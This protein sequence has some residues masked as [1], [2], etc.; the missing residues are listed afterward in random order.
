MSLA[1]NV[2]TVGSATLFSRV[3]GFA[4]DMGIAAVFG[5][6]I[7]ADAFFVAF[8][9]ANLIRRMLAEG[10]LNAAIVPL[11]LR[12]RDD[13]GETTAAAFAGRLIGS[14][15][16]GLIGLG[17]VSAVAMPAIV[18]LLAPGFVIGGPRTLLAVDMA[19]LMLPYLAFA[20]PLAVLMGVLNANGRFAAAAYATT[21]FNATMLAALAVVFWLGSGDSSLSGRIVAASVAL[22]GAAQLL[23]VAVAVWLAPQRVTPLAVSFAAP[24][25]RF[26]A[27]AIPGLV[28][29][30]IPQITVIAGV[31]VASASRSAV[32]WI[33][34]ANRLIE[35][36]LGIVGIA[37]GTVLVPAFTHAMRGGDKRALAQVE[38]RGLELALALALPAAVA[39][40]VLAEPIVRVLFERGAF[41]AADTV[42]TAAALSA[43][44]LGLPGHV[45][46]KTFSPVF[47]AREDT[48][49]PMRAALIG[50]VIAIV[51]SVL[52]MPALGHVGIALA[53]AL[54]GWL[55]ALLL[56]VLIAR[57]FGF[58]ID[59]EA[60][61]R[62]PRIALSAALMGLAVE[63]AHRLLQPWLG[64]AAPGALR[65]VV[66][67]ALVAFGLAAYVGLLALLRVTSP[68]DL[69][70]ALRRL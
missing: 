5:A 59:A 27:L 30:G 58:G 4:R 51:G 15:A 45:L 67:A 28:A 9:L 13:G 32:S 42:A 2:A 17:L 46:V 40:A 63:G 41:H 8:Q 49:T 66:L 64:G 56:G 61:R 47:F 3:L 55:S 1:R 31:M 14:S 19:R 48:G 16:L 6:G 11:Y 44:A 22:A 70:R 10:A 7:R 69:L 38:S 54:S 39:L 23:L 50:F 34:Y 25:R 26:L 37:I 43:F 24:M 52:M 68:R 12:A 60:R 20:G 53:T 18:L 21:A 65:A 35:L 57:R 29:S 62:L 33:Y 36:P